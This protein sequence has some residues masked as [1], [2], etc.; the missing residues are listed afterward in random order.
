[1]RHKEPRVA[2]NVRIPAPLRERLDRHVDNS[3]RSWPRLTV[4]D[5][6]TSAVT[7]VLDQ[8]DASAAADVARA[9]RKAA[10]VVRGPQLALKRGSKK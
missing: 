4:Q 1:M 2:L 10:P 9:V 8:A 5:I 7:L 6:V 3:A